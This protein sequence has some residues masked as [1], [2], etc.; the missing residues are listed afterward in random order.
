MLQNSPSEK[1]KQTD[2]ASLEPRTNYYQ[3]SPKEQDVKIPLV[4]GSTLPNKISP[5]YH[6]CSTISS[7]QWYC[8]LKRLG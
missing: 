8:S 5:V 4:I 3:I 6:Q 2:K 1:K 7:G